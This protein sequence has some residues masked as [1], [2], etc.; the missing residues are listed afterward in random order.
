MRFDED[1]SALGVPPDAALAVAVSG[2]PDSL[3]LLL[4]AVAARPGR[5]RAA[6]VDHGL[7]PEARAEAA[8]VAA[9]CAER[10]VP[11]EI[12]AV[13]VR[14]NIQSAAR[15]A[16]YHALAKWCATHGLSWLATAHHADDQ[17]ETLLMRLNRGSGLAGLAGVRRRRDLAP[18]L[19]LIRPLLEWRKAELEEIVIAAGLVPVQDPSN[20]DPAFDRTGIRRLLSQ[21]SALDP[22]R[23]AHSAGHLADAEEALAWA[24]DKAFAERWDATGLDPEGLPP[25]LVRRLVLRIFAQA[26]QTPRGPELARLIASLRQG[27]TATLAG[28]KAEPGRYWTFTASKPHRSR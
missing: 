28:L 18:G 8:A 6:T 19:T 3:A 2:G 26:G 13:Q 24:A 7:R 15:E 4:L 1:L 25:E 20:T 11:H 9:I 27:R 17:A 12:L 14:G 22:A 10:A 5:V 21:H 16:R 23:I